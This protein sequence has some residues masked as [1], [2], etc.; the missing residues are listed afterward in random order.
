MSDFLYILG[1]PIR[2]LL[3]VLYTKYEA[4]EQFFGYVNGRKR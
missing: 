4:Y 2:L 3:K 1:Y